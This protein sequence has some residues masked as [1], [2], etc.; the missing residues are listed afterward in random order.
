[1]KV[2]SIAMVAGAALLTIGMS[3]SADQALYT[4]KLCGTCH[5]M[6]ADTPIQPSYPK[7]AGQNSAYCQAQ[8]KDIKSGARANGLTAAMKP[9]V[10]TLTDAEIA[11]LCDYIQGL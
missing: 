2:K 6:D 4:A 1:M 11:T 10:A 5:G 3:A 7:L 9:M 8:V